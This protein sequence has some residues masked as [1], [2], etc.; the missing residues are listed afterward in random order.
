MKTF[1]LFAMITLLAGSLALPAHMA[2]ADAAP[3]SVLQVRVVAP[4]VFDA[5]REDDIKDTL[6]FRVRDA[7]ETKHRGLEVKQVDGGKADAKAPV[8]TL[9]LVNWRVTHMGD[10]ECRFAAEYS[11]ADGKRS[12]GMFEGTTS[13]LLRSRAFIGTDFERAA[14]EAGRRLGEALSKQGLI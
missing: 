2:A 7:L 10:I 3:K 5:I 11:S 8:L 6:F 12:L 14:E 9:S 1:R 4:F 13:S